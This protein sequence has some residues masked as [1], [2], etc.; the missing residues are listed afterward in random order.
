MRLIAP[1][2]L[3]LFGPVVVAIGPEGVGRPV[4]Y[5]PVGL[6][7]AGAFTVPAFALFYL[8]QYLLYVLV[9]FGIMALIRRVSSR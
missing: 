6:G 5:I 9:V 4:E 8:P 3:G 2:A 1:W 7:V